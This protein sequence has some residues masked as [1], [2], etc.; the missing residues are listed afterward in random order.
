MR[1]LSVWGE[2]WP[3][4]VAGALSPTITAIVLAILMNPNRPRARATAFLIGAVLSM[5]F[6][7]IL[8]SS[9]IWGVVTAT[10]HEIEQYGHS[11]DFVLGVLLIVFAL[12]R[13]LR[14]SADHAKTNPRMKDLSDGP[15][16]YQ[17]LFGAVMQGRNVTS[18]LLFCAAQ[19]HIDTSRLP[20][21]Q[22]LTLTAVIIAILVS[23]IWLPMLLP[24]RATDTLH[25]RLVPAKAWLESHSKVIEVGAALIGGAYLL[26]RAAS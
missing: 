20:A 4:A 25:S 24:I 5:V 3:M 6:W 26:F 8:V 14:K 12:W 22:E 1:M 2:I 19:Q 17:V 16:R 21:W 15:L 7:A 9:A 11:L 13:L 10:E 18:V 23:S